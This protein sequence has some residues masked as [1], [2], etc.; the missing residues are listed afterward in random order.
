MKNDFVSDYYLERYALGE[1]PAEEAEKI[2]HLASLDPS[3]Q[4]SLE[5]IESSN[6]D[7]QSAYSPAQFHQELSKR[8]AESKGKTIHDFSNVTHTFPHTKRFFVISTAFAS[9]LVLLILIWPGKENVLNLPIDNTQQDFSLVKGLQNIDLTKTQLLIFRKMSE[10]KVEI[11]T[12]GS[13][14]KAGDLLQLAYVAVQES[15]GMILSI[16]GRGSVTLHFPERIDDPTQLE[17]SRKYLL[18]NAIELDDAPDFERFFFLT[19]TSP[20]AVEKILNSVEYDTK[21]PAGLDV[22]KLKL[23]DGVKQHSVLIRKGDDHE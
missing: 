13:S 4:S 7:I 10:E 6:R 11:L 8:L 1:L 19:S 17:R 9:V 12:D 14:A 21:D 16:D 22:K 2:K 5:R 3:V 18:P 23:P 20:I 15:F